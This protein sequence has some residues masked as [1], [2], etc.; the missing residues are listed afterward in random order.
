MRIRLSN[1]YGDAPLVIGAASVARVGNG[2]RGGGRTRCAP[3]TFDDQPRVAVPRRSGPGQRSGPA[4]RRGRPGAGGE[5]PPVV[6][7]AG[8]HACT[9]SRCRPPTCPGAA[10]SRGPPGG[11][12]FG[13]PDQRPGRCSPVST[14]CSPAPSNAVVAVGDSI[15]D[16]F[17]SR[18]DTDQRWTD[19]LARRLADAGGRT[20]MAVLNAGLSANQLLADDPQR[21]GDSPITRFEPRRRRG[22]RGHRRGAAH[23]HQRHRRRPLGRGDHRRAAAVRRAGQGRPACGSSSPRSRP[24]RTGAHGTR[25]AVAT[26]NAVNAW[27]RAHGREHAD[28]VFDF[29]AAVADRATPTRLA[30]AYDSGDGL[31]LSAAG[32]RALAAAV[33]LR[34]AHREPVPGRRAGGTPCCWSPAADAL[35]RSLRPRISRP[36]RSR[37]RTPRRPAR[38]ARPPGRPA[39]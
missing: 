7:A 15:T 8:R 32:Y 17:G 3:V 16:G 37:P 39:R 35:P 22:R 1:V 28:G 30:A 4:G 26:R 9:R 23:R 12:P 13:T 21:G 29:A 11:G 34:R 25:T 14:C 36:A 33:D 6:R 27:I 10:T 5:P 38:S 24:S 19:A 2:G 18:V 20:P 31:H